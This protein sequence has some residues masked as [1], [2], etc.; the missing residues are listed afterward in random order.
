MTRQQN[1]SARRSMRGGIGFKPVLGGS[2]SRRSM[3]GGDR[4]TGQFYQGGSRRRR[5]MRGGLQVEVADINEGG[6]RRRRSMRGGFRPVNQPLLGGSRRR[7][8]MRGGLTGLRGR[9]TGD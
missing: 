6:S 8:S 2:R 3:R 4:D 5:S 1:R 7:R 9:P